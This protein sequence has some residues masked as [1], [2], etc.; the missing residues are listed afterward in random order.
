MPSLIKVAQRAAPRP[1]DGAGSRQLLE[2]I[3][4][5]AIQVSR[6]VAHHAMTRRRDRYE[7]RVGRAGDLMLE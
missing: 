2:E 7:L 4:D 5:R 3:L 6:L 1:V